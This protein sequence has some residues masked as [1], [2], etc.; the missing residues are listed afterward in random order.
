MYKNRLKVLIVAVISMFL[1]VILRLGYLQIVKGDDY[2]LQYEEMLKNIESLPALRGRILDRN[3]YILAYDEPCYSLYLD[4]RFLVSDK[5][6]AKRQARAIAKE[7]SLSPSSAEK[8]F[9]LRVDTTW[10]VVREA[11]EKARARE[12]KVSVLSPEQS[13][14][15]QHDLQLTIKRIVWRMKRQEKIVGMIVRGQRQAHRVVAGLG[16]TANVDL[17]LKLDKTV[18]ASLRPDNRRRYPYRTTACHIIGFT[19]QVWK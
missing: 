9:R 18:G 8:V 17:S 10:R 1:G 13:A 4:Y 7:L 11:A 12:L 14:T 6:W 15:V 16:E 2:R 19:T 3:G 5:R